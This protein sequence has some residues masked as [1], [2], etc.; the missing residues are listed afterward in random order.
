MLRL[1]RLSWSGWNTFTHIA[2]AWNWTFCYSRK[3]TDAHIT[4]TVIRLH[5]SDGITSPSGNLLL[6]Y[7]LLLCRTSVLFQHRHFLKKRIR[8]SLGDL[9]CVAEIPTRFTEVLN[10]LEGQY[11]F[12]CNFLDIFPT[13]FFPFTYPY[14]GRRIFQCS[15]NLSFELLTCKSS[16]N[17]WRYDNRI[18]SKSKR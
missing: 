10:T 2:F 5:T 6:D 18:R 11:Y 13:F 16:I 1:K 14:F 3:H 8:Y 9:T 15:L 12:Y 17:I 4:H 7:V